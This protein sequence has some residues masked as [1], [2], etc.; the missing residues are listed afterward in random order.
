MDEIKQFGHLET[1]LPSNQQPTFRGNSGPKRSP[2]QA[3]GPRG[4]SKLAWTPALVSV[5]CSGSSPTRSILLS[6]LCT[7]VQSSED[8]SPVAAWAWTRGIKIPIPTP[9]DASTIPPPFHCEPE[10]ADRCFGISQYLIHRGSSSSEAGS[11]LPSGIRPY[12][13]LADLRASQSP[14]RRARRR[15]A[16]PKP[17]REKLFRVFH[18]W[19]CQVPR[20]VQNLSSLRNDDTQD[21]SAFKSI[22]NQPRDSVAWQRREGYV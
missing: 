20:R 22:I 2:T 10:C 16:S 19:I 14:A 9:R 17:P 13:T 8:R 12:R 6:G 11:L 5:H 7:P 4:N 3:A 18:A 21:E 15:R 1:H